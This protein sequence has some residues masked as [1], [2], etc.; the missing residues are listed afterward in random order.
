MATETEAAFDEASACACCEDDAEELAAAACVDEAEDEAAATEYGGEGERDLERDDGARGARDGADDEEEEPLDE[1]AKPASDI[2]ASTSS[3]F[4]SAC[5][6]A[7]AKNKHASMRRVRHV[8]QA[9]GSHTRIIVNYGNK[10]H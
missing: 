9:T 1:G 4:T 5:S 10:S 2:R 6:C 8:A 3:G 7:K